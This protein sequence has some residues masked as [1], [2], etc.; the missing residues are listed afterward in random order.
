LSI[1]NNVVPPT[2][3]HFTDDPELPQLDYTF[4]HKKERIVNYA[5]SNTFGFGGHNVSLLFAKYND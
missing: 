4:N 5:I 3:N 1:K 2:I